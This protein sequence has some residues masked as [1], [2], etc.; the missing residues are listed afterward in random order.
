[1]DGLRAPDGLR[2]A[3]CAGDR[4]KIGKADLDAHRPPCQ[5]LPLEVARNLDCHSLQGGQHNV[6]VFQI[7]GKVHS[8]PT[9]F[10]ARLGCTGRWSM[11]RAISANQAPTLPNWAIKVSRGV[12]DEAEAH[13][14]L[15]QTAM[16]HGKKIGEI[17]AMIIDGEERY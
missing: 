14:R 3:I 7:L 1:M 12:I 15:R 11:P 17:A 6:S 9:D 2:I 5:S 16:N 4:R 10:L 8:L 13:K